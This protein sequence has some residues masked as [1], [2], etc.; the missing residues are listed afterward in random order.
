MECLPGQPLM[1]RDNLGSMQVANVAQ[2]G[3]A[4]L[5]TLGIQAAALVPIARD[6]L[7]PAGKK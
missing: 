3:V 6:Y 5:D 4:G 2:A 1:S 7:S